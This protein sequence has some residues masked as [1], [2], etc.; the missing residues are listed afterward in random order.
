[1][2]IRTPLH[3]VSQP[4]IC[5]L[6]TIL[7]W[8]PDIDG[9]GQGHAAAVPFDRSTDFTGHTSGGPVPQSGVP[10]LDEMAG[11]WLN[12]SELGLAPAINNFH[13]GPSS[14]FRVPLFAARTLNATGQS[15]VTLS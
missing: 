2:N 11:Q 1:M 15:R 3:A 5:F 7:F 13:G 9:L 14:P 8:A 12:T 4:I 10:S 6:S